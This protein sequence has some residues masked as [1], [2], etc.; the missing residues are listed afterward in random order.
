MSREQLFA[1]QRHGEFSITLE[2]HLKDTEEAAA[3]LFDLNRRWGKNWCRFFKIPEEDRER[4]LLHVRLASLFH[5]I[6]KANEDFQDMAEGTGHCRQQRLRHE[7]L[8]ALL[9]H[10]PEVRSWLAENSELD[11][12]VI[13]SAVLSHHLKASLDGEEWKWCQPRAVLA[14]QRLRLPVYFG[15]REVVAVL[16]RVRQVARLSSRPPK[17]SMK[18]WGEHEPWITAYTEGR[19]LAKEFGRT[20]RDGRDERRRALLLATKAG[21]IVADAVASGLVREG[22]SIEDWIDEVTGQEEVSPEEVWREVILPRTEEIAKKRGG[23]FEFHRFQL[24]AADLGPRALLLAACGAG[25]T[26]A[27]WKWAR[28]QV[29]RTK[30][31][32]VVFLY[33]TRGTATEGFR[34][35]VG[36][37]P[38][39]KAAL[40]HGTSRYELE[41]MMANPS[42]ATQGKDFA[43]R[44]EDERLY[45]LGFWSRRFFSATVDQFLG[46]MEHGYRSLCLLPVLADSVVIV[47]EVHSFDRKMFETLKAFL[48]AFDVPVLCMT[49]TLPPGRRDELEKLGLEIYPKAGDRYELQDLDKNERAPRYCI[50]GVDGEE[51][52]FGIAVEAYRSGKRVLWVVNQ[53][54]RCQRIAKRLSE[55]LERNSIEVLCYH[56]RFRLMDR[57]QVHARTV[58]AFKQRGRPAIAV[59]TQVCEMSLDLDAEVLITELASV[60]ALVQRFGRVNR[61]L[62]NGGA[63]RGR[64]YT[65]EPSN[66]RPYE[67]EDIEAARKF[68]REVTG[69]DTSQRMLAEALE[70]HAPEE[71]EGPAT[72]RFLTAG[73]F[74]TVGAFRDED[75][76]SRM[77]V[78]D[79]DLEDVRVCLEKKQAM[80]GYVVSVPRKAVLWERTRPDWLPGYLGIASSERY[81]PRWGFEVEESEP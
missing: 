62:A 68:L 5:D 2:R 61:H 43:L 12:E 31:S 33:P 52:A 27:A 48:G 8:S 22:R 29:G 44:E 51:Q 54:S 28:A 56:S 11:L 81:H 47:D 78:L 41:G 25:K 1:K 18:S 24:G 79:G 3:R 64:V 59:T 46:F 39:A 23:R 69:M 74:A 53:V 65:Y 76:G 55:E 34:D 36:W 38:E 16:E 15:H 9:L 63:T 66:A 67:P 40:V 77:C 80:D 42:E 20:V 6:G 72:A 35:Y 71:K 10:V 37:A 60:T 26:L 14:G 58:E 49:A 70:R 4:F 32:K 19:K 50:E 75:H 57:Q 21:L 30:V 13:A 45:A 73:Y 7:H 17:L